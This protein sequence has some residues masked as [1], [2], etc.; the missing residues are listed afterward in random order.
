MK[1]AIT[2]VMLM[3]IASVLLLLA[4]P[5]PIDAVAYRAPE[6]PPATGILTPNQRL[7]EAT[8]LAKG[9]IFGPEDVAVDTLGRIY[10]GTQD[11]KIMRLHEGQL[12]LFVDL[13]A[14]GKRARPLGLHFDQQDNLIVCDAW[15]GLLSISPEGRVTVLATEAEGVPFAFADDLDIARDG[16]IYFS[17]ASSR[18]H[19]PDYALDLLEARPWGRLLAYNPATGT[20]RVLMR[21]LYFANGVALSANE[22]FVLV[23]ETYRY[24]IQRYWLKGPKA[25]THD[26]FIDNLPGLPDGVSGNRKGTFWVA[27]ATPRKA[28]IDRMHMHPRIKNLIAKLPRFMWPKPVRYGYVLALDE[29]GEITSSLHDPSGEHL[30]MVTSAEEH[31]GY[32]YLGSLHNDRIGRLKL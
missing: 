6:P 27:L 7:T 3:L 15:Q 21:D 16:I 23:N 19:Q 17:D 13:G 22:D 18:F 9:A 20:I 5:S 29:Q 1:K 14:Q 8:L 10:G 12:E 2:L 32:L 26:L 25:G 24:R 4:F 30:E 31:N 28:S 11:G